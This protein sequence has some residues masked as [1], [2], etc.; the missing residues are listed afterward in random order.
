MINSFHDDYIKTFK[1]A[2]HMGWSFGVHGA[3]GTVDQ[4]T[5]D[6]DT[7]VMQWKKDIEVN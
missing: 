7:N 5:K 3:V 4:I 1:F 2:N 6:F